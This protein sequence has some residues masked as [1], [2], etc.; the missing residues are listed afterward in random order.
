MTQA[1]TPQ[2]SRALLDRWRRIEMQVRC[3]LSPE[4]PGCVRIYV[5]AGLHIVRLGL[6]PPLEVYPHLLHTL[7]RS[8]ADEALPWFWRSVCLENL[9]LP[10]AKLSSL[11]GV[12][13]PLA[14]EAWHAYVQQA[15]ESLP[16]TPA[17]TSFDV[18]ESLSHG[19]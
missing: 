2:A 3:G 18:F 16:V 7:L 12:H 13:D 1:L 17:K 9:N 19:R 11:L 10:L 5:H 4:Q 15:R 8:A 14:V 6:K